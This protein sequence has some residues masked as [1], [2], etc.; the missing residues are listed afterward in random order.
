LKV[1]LGDGRRIALKF[2]VVSKPRKKVQP[3]NAAKVKLSEWKIIVMYH[4]FRAI[5]QLLLGVSYK[6]EYVCIVHC[7]ERKKK[8]VEKSLKR[9]TF[10]RSDH[11]GGLSISVF[12]PTT[13]L[14]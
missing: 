10:V 11:Y 14:S 1:F 12:G 13:L 7:V 3:G 4:G 2:I 9:C 6:V 8:S 5:L